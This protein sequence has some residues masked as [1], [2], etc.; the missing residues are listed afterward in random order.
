MFGR[1]I[2][3]E[4]GPTRRGGMN[5][6]VQKNMAILEHNWG[7][8]MDIEEDPTVEAPPLS[9]E[10]ENLMDDIK[11]KRPDEWMQVRDTVGMEF[12]MLVLALQ[13]LAAM[14]S[15]SYL[16]TADSGQLTWSTECWGVWTKLS[17]AD[18]VKK[19]TFDTDLGWRGYG[20]NNAYGSI[21]KL[22][23]PTFIL[24]FMTAAASTTSVMFCVTFVIWMCM[25]VYKSRYRVSRYVSEKQEDEPPTTSQEIRTCWHTMELAVRAHRLLRVIGGVMCFTGFW[26]LAFGFLGYYYSLNGVRDSITAMVSTWGEKVSCDTPVTSPRYGF[27]A[28]A[29]NIL[30][31][32]GGGGLILIRAI[33]ASR[34][35]DEACE[36]WEQDQAEMKLSG[37]MIKDAS[38]LDTGKTMFSPDGGFRSPAPITNRSTLNRSSHSL[39]RSSHSQ[40]SQSSTSVF[41]NAGGSALAALAGKFSHSATAPRGASPP[42]PQAVEMYN[43]SSPVPSKNASNRSPSPAPNGA[44]SKGRSAFISQPKGVNYENDDSDDDKEISWSRPNNLRNAR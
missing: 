12:M 41:P 31:Q 37:G 16:S 1:N 22:N 10:V 9:G 38:D 28:N 23:R 36:L 40:E 3:V 8:D 32:L 14:A 6:M 26:L 19:V 7:N 11:E 30:V 25:L 39:N 17:N 42:P 2:K 29:L 15:M 43:M 44:Y 24:G 20:H 4:E 21:D 35:L 13:L 33:V 27:I 5:N 34:E 18:G